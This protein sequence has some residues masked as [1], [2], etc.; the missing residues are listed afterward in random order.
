[1]K[2]YKGKSNETCEANKIDMKMRLSVFTN[3]SVQ[4]G[5][6]NGNF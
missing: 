2:F 3:T 4:A 1:M 5:C 6:D